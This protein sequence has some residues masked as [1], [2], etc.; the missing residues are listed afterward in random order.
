M[1]FA[2]LM[3]MH[4]LAPLL[5]VPAG[6]G[7]GGRRRRR[8]RREHGAPARAGATREAQSSCC[9]EPSDIV[10][11]ATRVRCSEPIFLDEGVDEYDPESFILYT[12]EDRDEIAALAAA[13]RTEPSSSSMGHCMCIGTLVFTFE[14]P[15]PLV[16]TLHQARASAGAKPTR[17]SRSSIRTP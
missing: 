13:L 9:K 1:C 12:T 3:P 10:A 17:T 6:A 7:A 4:L 11:S 15:Q 14:G 8:R 2:R 5:L 16:A